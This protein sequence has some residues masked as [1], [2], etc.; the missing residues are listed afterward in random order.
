MGTTSRRWIAPALL[1]VFALAAC[2]D[3]AQA[4]G[5]TE[6]RVAQLA[7]RLAEGASDY[8]KTIL[9]DGQVTPAEYERAVR[10]AARCAEGE[11]LV[12]DGPTTHPD[13]TTLM[14][15]LS[16]SEGDDEAEAERLFDECWAE[17]TE[18]VAQVWQEHNIPSAQ[19]RAEQ[20]AALRACLQDAGVPTLPEAATA[21]MYAEAASEHVNETQDATAMECYLRYENI[22]VDGVAIGVD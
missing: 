15:T 8:Q 13:G 21:A 2:T 16:T 10:D 3:T 1:V 11:G 19:D 5:E 9:A 7:A 18:A 14:L 4:E 20:L 6:G 22:F 17:H 12:V